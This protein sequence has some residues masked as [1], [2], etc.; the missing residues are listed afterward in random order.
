MYFDFDSINY[1]KEEATLFINN[2]KTILE[3]ELSIDINADDY[4]VLYN[5]GK[6]KQENPTPFIQSLHIIV[7]SYKMDFKQ[8]NIEQSHKSAS[9]LTGGGFKEK[10]KENMTF[11]Y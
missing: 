9:F 8:Q 5:E 1:S 11:G 2:F 7:S 4:I 10:H 6:D 3:I